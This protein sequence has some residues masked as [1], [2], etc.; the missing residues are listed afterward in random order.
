MIHNLA[1]NSLIEILTALAAV[2]II[3]LLWKFRNLLE[4]KFLIYLEVFAGIWALTYAFEFAST[5]LVT[6]IFWSKMSYLGIAFLPV[7]YFLFTTA[8]SQKNNIINSRKIAFLTII[9]LITLGLVFTNESHHL[10]WS[11]VTLDKANN[12]AHYHHGVWF[13]VFFGYTQLLIFLG[14]YNLGY[15]IYKFTA[16]YKSQIGVLLV[17]SLFPIVGNLLYITNLNPY[18]GFDWTPVSFVLT[19]FTIALGM[20][21]YR[22]FDIVPL[23]KNKLFETMND[24]AIIVNEE[25]IIEDCNPVVYTILNRQKNSVIR[26]PFDKIFE[27]YQMLIDAVKNRMACTQLEIRQ[28]N[29]TFYYQVKISPIL[30]NNNFTGNL[31][32][33]HDITSLR[34]AEEELK[35]T[36]SQLL[37]EIEKREKLIEEL[38]TFAH[39]VA[40]DLRNTLGS[41]FSASEIMEEIIKEND[42]NLLFELT[43]LI[44]DSAGKSIQITHELLL[45][46]TTEK[47]NIECKELDMKAIFGEA[48]KQ[49]D[50]L[51]VKSGAQ[52]KEPET[53]PKSLGYA[54]WIEEVWTNYISNAIKYGGNPPVVEIGTHF[55]PNGNVMFWVKDN[56]KGISPEDQKKLFKNFMRLDPQKA[57]GYGLGLS[58]VKRIVEKLDGKVGIESLG[59]GNGSKFY[60]TLPASNLKTLPLNKINSIEEIMLN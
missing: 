54:P 47:Q 9:P 57:E 27:K 46:A 3:M 7:C 29:H 35:K 23:A 42:K 6:K 12:M 45:L 39:T 4:V 43:N 16:Y 40:H 41:I 22:M 19:G 55:L 30:R 28:G 51:I 24:G 49:L 13:W 18:P 8:F 21:K 60:F 11:D 48:K 5:E 37:I 1:T 17:A 59:D 34:N 20:S 14:V 2:N 25:G 53:W 52:I 50:E 58:I 31:L 56:G 33:L 32:I 36:N 26:E 15:S 38:D 44:N 10:V